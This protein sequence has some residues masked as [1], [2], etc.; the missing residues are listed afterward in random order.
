MSSSNPSTIKCAAAANS[1]SPTDPSTSSTSSTS[2]KRKTDNNN[3]SSNDNKKKMKASK[4]TSFAF[5]TKEIL[6][7]QPDSNDFQVI[8]QWHQL[9]ITIDREEI[10][11]QQANVL[12]LEVEARRRFNAGDDVEA[13]KLQ[14]EANDIRQ[15]Y[16]ER[17]SKYEKAAHAAYL[18]NRA[19]QAQA[20]ESN[21]SCAGEW[22][23]IL[24][25]ALAIAK[26]LG[27]AEKALQEWNAKYGML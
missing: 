14:N 21:Y 11:A 7:L 4:M 5:G 18:A 3:N 8:K 15:E 26:N 24:T 1:D 9:G 23:N 17:L 13:T 27:E 20:G 19:M 16:K 2:T 12:S 25:A 6:K 10:R 22:R